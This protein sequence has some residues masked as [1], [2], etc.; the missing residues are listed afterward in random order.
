MDLMENILSFNLGLSKDFSLFAAILGDS[1]YLQKAVYI[2][3]NFIFM[4]Q[5]HVECCRTLY[6]VWRLHCP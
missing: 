2:H 1:Y 6:I 3:N 4:E 5:I